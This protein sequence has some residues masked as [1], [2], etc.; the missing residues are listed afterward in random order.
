MSKKIR[1][2]MVGYKFM[3][4]AHS[5]AWRQ[6]PVFFDS[7]L[8]PELKAICGRD[9]EGVKAAAEKYGW[10]SYETSWKKL[11]ERDDI[12]IVDINTPNSSHAEIAIAAAEHGKHVFIEKPLA[13]NI[14]EAKRIADAVRKAGVKHMV[15]FNYR[16]FPALTFAKQIMNEGRLGKIFHFRALYL[17]DWIVD[18][19][20]PL[21]WRLDKKTAG[22]GALGDLCAHIVDMAL[23]LVGDIKSVSA[24]AETFIKKRKLPSQEGGLSAK[25]GEKTGEVT[26]DDAVISLARFE[27]GALG[28][29]EVTRFAIGHKNGG[30]FEINGSK[31]SLRFNL[32]RMN[33]LELLSAE[34]GDEQGFK[35]ILVTEST[36]PFMAAW[37]PPGH[38][39]GW[40]HSQINQ[41]YHLLESIA[42]DRMPEP[43]IYD[44]LKNQAVL[45]AMG[46]SMED[47]RW[48][49]V[50]KMD[51]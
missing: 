4:K 30:A 47:G 16:R 19:D 22:S 49:E 35:T 14:E 44:G 1:V 8:V 38:M 50:E 3:G 26:V 27:N 43:S 17:Q 28:T 13:M 24:T 10:E 41:V 48:H 33:E 42:A 6:V 46:R 51:G 37:W 32:E 23:W 12:D 40:E 45:E 39:I 21:V 5:N 29:F 18:P 34:D 25:A 36:H 2:G 11:V 15:S 20:F 31:G 9:E 7:P